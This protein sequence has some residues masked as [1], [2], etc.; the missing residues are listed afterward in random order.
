MSTMRPLPIKATERPLLL[1]DLNARVTPDA[2]EVPRRLAE[3]M[4]AQDVRNSLQLLSYAQSFPSALALAFG[5]SGDQVTSA[6][7]RLSNQLGA[8]PPP[9]R[10][11]AFGARNPD[12]LN[13]R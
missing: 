4:A 7:T 8:S 10:M 2:I 5:W 1:G 11:V 13:N 3:E 6:V 9:R 12:E